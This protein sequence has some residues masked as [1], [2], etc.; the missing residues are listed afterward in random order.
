MREKI[1][2]VVFLAIAALSILIPI[3]DWIGALDRVPFI[4]DKLGTCTLLM[5]GLIAMYLIS[6][7][8]QKLDRIERLLEA[9][10]SNIEQL[11]EAT[12][13]DVIR[14][15]S[16]VRV[17]RFE[18]NEELYDYVTQRLK[19]ARKS[20]DDLT[21]GITEEER[22]PAAK[23]ALDRYVATMIATIQGKKRLIYREVMSFAPVGHVE[24]ARGMLNLNLWNYS[25]RYYDGEISTPVLAFIII[26]GEEVIISSYRAPYLPSAHEIRLATTH[27]DIVALFRDYYDTIWVGAQVLKDAATSF[28]EKLAAI[29][30]R[31]KSVP[32]LERED[33]SS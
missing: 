20:V 31:L 23:A 13:R 19:Q 32:A 26:D 22:T 8:R 18:Q 3:A 33:H 16:G 25:L 12:T 9:G 15:L 27:P 29:E 2:H 10:T 6:E 5:V 7:R 24:R 4:A 14:S 11:I 1:E 28:P 30:K 17:R 21:W